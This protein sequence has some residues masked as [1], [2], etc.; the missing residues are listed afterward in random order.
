MIENKEEE[1]LSLRVKAATKKRVEDEQDRV[2]RLRGKKITQ[3]EVIESAM[4]ALVSGAAPASADLTA[5]LSPENRARVVALIEM[6]SGESTGVEHLDLMKA[7][8]IGYLDTWASQTRKTLL[9]KK[10]SGKHT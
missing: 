5:G 4:D 2:R 3:T 8:V 6:L 9:G 7:P 10:A 1:F